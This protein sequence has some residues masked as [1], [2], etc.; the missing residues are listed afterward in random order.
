MSGF[1]FETLPTGQGS[2]VLR[3]PTGKHTTRPLT[4]DRIAVLIGL[5]MAC[6]AGGAQGWASAR[7]VEETIRAHGAAGRWPPPPCLLSRRYLLTMWRDGYVEKLAGKCATPMPVASDHP[8]WDMN[9][10]RLSARGTAELE[11][12]FAPRSVAA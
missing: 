3:V 6:A 7:M 11:Q 2:W 4:P 12:R 8:D 9:W 1:R 5:R 10:W